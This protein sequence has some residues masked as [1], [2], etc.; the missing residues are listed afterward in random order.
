MC[1]VMM[2]IGFM[3]ALLARGGQ[4]T[5]GQ[6]TGVRITCFNA[7]KGT[8]AAVFWLLMVTLHSEHS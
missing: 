8:V 5:G 2:F 4:H 7:H 1:L 6:H 3:A